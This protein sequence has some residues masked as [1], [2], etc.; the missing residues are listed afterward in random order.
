[1]I[2]EQ[3]NKQTQY[4]IISLLKRIL[5]VHTVFFKELG[6]KAADSQRKLGAEFSLNRAIR[7]FPCETCWFLKAKRNV[8]LLIIVAKPGEMFTHLVQKKLQEEG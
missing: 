1:M 7:S 5:A 8:V 4:R 3:T 6:W 2:Q